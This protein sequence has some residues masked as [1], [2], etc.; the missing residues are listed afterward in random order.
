MSLMSCKTQESSGIRVFINEY[1]D[2]DSMVNDDIVLNNYRKEDEINFN[3]FE[4]DGLEFSNINYYIGGTDYCVSDGV[5]SK[6]E[7]HDAT[8]CSCL[9][10][11]EMF[12]I[13]QLS[14]NSKFA[15]CFR[16]K[17][18]DQYPVEWKNGTSENE[19]A[20]ESRFHLFGNH[21]LHLKNSLNENLVTLRYNNID[22]EKALIIQ[23]SIRAYFETIAE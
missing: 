15:I 11:R 21:Y 12:I 9:K 7:E 3:N 18:N 13:Y 2:Y 8:H 5:I 22:D 14:D 20:Y 10:N 17:T 16:K 23:N 4:F 1:A 6:I 19:Y